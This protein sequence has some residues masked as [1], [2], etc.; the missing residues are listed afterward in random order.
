MDQEGIK[1]DLTKLTKAELTELLSQSQ[2]Q[3]NNL[4]TVAQEEIE[5]CHKRLDELEQV[6]GNYKAKELAYTDLI[7]NL[8][9]ANFEGLNETQINSKLIKRMMSLKYYFGK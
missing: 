9:D 8:T 6:I 1:K 5:G 7:A 2:E 4:V 3:Y